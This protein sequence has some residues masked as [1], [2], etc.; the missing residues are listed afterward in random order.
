VVFTEKS[1]LFQWLVRIGALCLCLVCLYADAAP[2]G[3][4]AMRPLLRQLAADGK[5]QLAGA[6]IYNLPVT[7]AFYQDNGERPA[8]TNPAVL[9]ELDGAIAQAWREGMNGVDFHQQQVHALFDG[10]LQLPAPERDLLLTDSLVRLTYLYALG[11]VDPGKY[12][13]AWNFDRD[14][15][16]TDPVQW[17]AQVV[18]NGGIGAS[19]D[20]LKP[21]NALYRG[22]VQ[23]L[24]IYRALAARGGWEPVDPGPTLHPGD[25]GPRV[26]QLRRRLQ[27][28]DMLGDNPAEDEDYF[29]ADLERGVKH[30]QFHHRLDEDGI[31][32]RQSLAALN[33]PVA[34]RIGQIRV[35]LERARVLRDIPA[36]S[37]VVDIAGFE[38]L[39]FRDGK[40]LLRSRAQVGKPY[41][42]TPVFRDEITYIEFNPTWTVPPTILK[43]D[44]L[45]AIRQN[46]DY[47]QARNMQVLTLD[48]VEVN[49]QTI[50][51]QRYPQQGFPYLI[52]QLPG[53]DNALGRI[54]IM[55]PNEHQV[56]LHDTPSREL[57]RRNERTFSSGCI[58]VEQIEELTELLLDD[59]AKW[60]R[61]AIDATVASRQT[62]RVSLPAPMP[63]YLVYWTVQVT[64][65]GEVQ[66]KLDPYSRDGLILKV[67]DQPL[68]PDPARIQRKS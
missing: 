7:Q 20:R 37:V 42:S 13:T 65:D 19:L 62:R 57:F 11:K 9:A 25:R 51:W 1:F 43:Q 45:P 31:V 3:E 59:P 61:A 34:G 58:R 6:N 68:V 15:P 28:E 36:T 2:A 30:F 39:L 41:R 54:K 66:F 10:S 27:A 14:L 17:L 47:L 26:A 55:F 40:R 67:L 5:L 56:Y 8:W 18:P 63:I 35:N 4:G 22:L 24:A 52:R 64:D 23:A 33:V 48:G 44:V 46:P 12:T 53:P 16:D 21:A 38:V 50:D 29:D 49:P 32:G 60:N